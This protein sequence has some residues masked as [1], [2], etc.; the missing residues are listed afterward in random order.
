MA[1]QNGLSFTYNFMS[2]KRHNRVEHNIA[3]DV[4]RPMTSQNFDYSLQLFGE[5]N[6]FD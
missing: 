3:Q 5:V 2:G 1:T 4:Q 6:V